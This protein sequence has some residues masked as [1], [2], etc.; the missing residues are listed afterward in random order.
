M[1]AVPIRLQHRVININTSYAGTIATT[2]ALPGLKNNQRTILEHVI[3]S[4]ITEYHVFKN[5]TL[6]VF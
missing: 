6:V 5:G 3:F 1:L 4:D 2:K